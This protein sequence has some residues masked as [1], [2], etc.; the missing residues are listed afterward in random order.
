MGQSLLIDMNSGWYKHKTEVNDGL[1]T[2][3]YNQVLGALDA[4]NA[5]LPDEYRII[6]DSEEYDERIKA[7][8]VA[9]CKHCNTDYPDPTD[10]TKFIEGPTQTE[11]SKLK[12]LRLL[13]SSF[14]QLAEGKKYDYFWCCEK[15]QGLNQYSKTRFKQ[16]VLKKPYYLQLVPEPPIKHLGIEDRASY[17]NKF[18]NWARNFLA[19][20]NAS[21]QRF[22]QEY[23]PKEGEEG[24]GENLDIKDDDLYD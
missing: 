10:K 8:L 21:A 7:N 18:E 1:K 2:R 24:F 22:R 4:L 3:S 5:L 12:R 15:C 19:E 13:L 16:K 23:K 11:H 20:L 6:V 14:D 9:L 17:H